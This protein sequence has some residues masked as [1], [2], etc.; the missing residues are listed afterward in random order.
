[1]ASGLPPPD[2]LAGLTSDL[3]ITT[4]NGGRSWQPSRV[5][6]PGGPINAVGTASPSTVWA[7]AGIP[8]DYA[9]LAVW[10]STD[11]GQHW[12]EVGTL[13][14]ATTPAFLSTS[15]FDLEPLGSMSGWLWPSGTNHGLGVGEESLLSAGLFHTSNGGR[16]W[17][18]Y[19]LPKSVTTFDQSREGSVD[20][21]PVTIQFLSDNPDIGWILEYP[22]DTGLLLSPTLWRTTDGGL[23]WIGQPTATN[24]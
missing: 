9:P 19:V 15:T 12:S 8:D 10:S 3:L 2:S 1:M 17:T 6:M 13:P 22:Q 16:T 23:H 18:H 21:E 14:F 20:L 11:A 5:A 24:V 7:V 4:T